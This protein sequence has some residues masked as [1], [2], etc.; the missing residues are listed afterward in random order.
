MYNQL[1][2]MAKISGEYLALEMNRAVILK[3]EFT[4]E[5]V[6]YI[7]IHPAFS[8]CQITLNNGNCDASEQKI[9]FLFILK[10]DQQSSAHMDQIKTLIVQQG[11]LK[12]ATSNQKEGSQNSVIVS[13]AFWM[14]EL[15]L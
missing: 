11:M 4:P 10:A 15:S 1:C 13:Y 9:R 6:A 3:A 7:N 8:L 2:P 12:G 14:G 5:S